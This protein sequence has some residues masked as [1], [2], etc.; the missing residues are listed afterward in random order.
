MKRFTFLPLPFSLCLSLLSAGACSGVDDSS[1]L[2]QPLVIHAPGVS[3]KSG[4]LPGLPPE[5]QADPQ[6]PRV[7]V[8]DF[9]TTIVTPEL[10]ELDVPGRTSPKAVA[11]GMR[12][13]DFGSGYWVLPVGSADPS[14]GNEMIWAVD[15]AVN[16]LPPGSHKL[17]FVAID[18]E[19]RAGPQVFRS[20]CVTPNVPDN[21]NICEPSLPPPA[22]VL[23]LHWDT[24]A[25]LDLE[26]IKTTGETVNQVLPSFDKTKANGYIDIDAQ[27][28]CNPGG[29]RRENLIWSNPPA[30]GTYLVFVNLFDACHT[31]GANFKTQLYRPQP[32]PD[33]TQRLIEADWAKQGILLPPSANGGAKRGLF[34][35]TVTF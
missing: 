26:V 28:G 1:G 5:T 24:G 20:I 17:L 23:S 35:G 27:R 25:D 2:D 18:A 9:P 16:Y 34:V 14:N 8:V 10:G 7:T 15:L 29:V 22:A 6:L 33:G 11:V 30:P 4:V 19:G 32:Q 21:L 31:A 13:A 3:F 12:F